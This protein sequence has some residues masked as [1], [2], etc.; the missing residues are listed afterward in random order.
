MWTSVALLYLYVTSM[1]TVRILPDLMF[2]HVKLDLRE[3]EK[4]APVS[5]DLRLS[6]VF[7]GHS[8]QMKNSISLLSQS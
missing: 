2:V 6:V 3:M 8:D 1:P 4:L 7:G 5:I